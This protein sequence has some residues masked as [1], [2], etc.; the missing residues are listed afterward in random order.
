MRESLGA[1]LKTE[2]KSKTAISKCTR[3]AIASICVKV[4]VF[5]G[6]STGVKATIAKILLKRACN[7]FY[8]SQ[9]NFLD[10]F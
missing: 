4:D 2:T 5:R 9:S 1:L 10:S 3:H 8:S 6:V 7:F